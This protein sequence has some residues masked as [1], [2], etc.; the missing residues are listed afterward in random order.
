MFPVFKNLEESSTSKNLRPHSWSYTFSV[1]S[2]NPTNNVLCNTALYV[3]DT[4]LY[5]MFDPASDS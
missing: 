1:Y 5:S 4:T 3:D 2:N